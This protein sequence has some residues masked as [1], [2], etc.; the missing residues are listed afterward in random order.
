[1]TNEQ[2][3][4]IYLVCVCTGCMLI[5]PCCGE[6]Y[7]CRHCHNEEHEIN[8]KDSKRA[9]SLD[10]F[11]VKEIV[12]SRCNT[13]Q[14]VQPKCQNCENVFGDYFCS[15]SVPHVSWSFLFSI[16]ENTPAL[17]KGG[18]GFGFSIFLKNPGHRARIPTLI[19]GFSFRGKSVLFVKIYFFVR[20]EAGMKRAPLLRLHAPYQGWG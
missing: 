6:R 8:S 4:Y 16:L 15:V 10:R 12:C 18:G 1:M 20:R 3:L 9:H 13:T 17:E 11:A 14:R 7:W 19:S 5:S 2:D